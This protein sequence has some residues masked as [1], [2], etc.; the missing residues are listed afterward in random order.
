MLHVTR[1]Q[2]Q[3]AA[4]KH[5]DQ[6]AERI[7]LEYHERTKHHYHRFATSSGYMDW[8]TQPDPF[9]RYLGAPLIELPMPEPGRTMQYRQL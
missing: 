6:S 4:S 1:T 9:R 7:V 2:S 5:S 3:G 8:A